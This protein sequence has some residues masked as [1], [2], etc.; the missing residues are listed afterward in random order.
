MFRPLR[1][2]RSIGLFL[3]S[4]SV[5]SVAW[6]QAPIAQFSGAPLTGN[7]PL[8]VFFTDFSTGSI[9]SRSWTFGDGGTSN[10]ED[11]SHE[12]TSPGTYTVSLSV[13]GPGGTDSE[14][15]TGY[16]VVTAPPPVANF[17]ATPLS[18]A[19][20]L[21]VAFTS[22][23]TGTITSG[24]WDFGDGTTSTVQNP[25]KLY[26]SPGTYTV[27]LTVS[28]PG[29][30]DTETKVGYITVANAPPVADFSGTPL[31]GMPPLTAFFTSLS[32]GAI[33]GYSW[34][35]GDG[36]TSTA[37][38]PSHAYASPG[39]YTVSLTV[40]GPGGTDTET[41][42]DY[43]TVG[44]LAP[45]AAFSGTPLSGVSPLTVGFTDLSTNTV[46]TRS[47]NFGDGGTSTA[48]NPS[49]VYSSPGSYTVSLTVT[50]PGGSDSEIK[51]DYVVVS[52]PPPVAQFFGSPLTGAAPLAVNFTDISSGVV[53]GRS[54]SFGDGISSTATNPSH[55]YTSPGSYT[56]SLTVVGPGGSDVETKTFYVVVLE[57]APVAQ[58]TG[59]PT[60]GVAPL[61][62]NFT[63][64]SS[65]NINT[66]SW[67]FGDGGSSTLEN[68]SH[69]Y[70]AAGTYTVSLTVSSA[71]GGDT[72]TKVG[73]ITVT[74]PP[75]VAE[76]SGT[77]LAG[78]P[79]LTV[80]FTNMST[81]AITSRLWD[82]GDLSTSTA[83][84][85]SHSYAATGA[86]TVTLTVTGPGGTD[87]ER[88]VGYVVVGQ[89]A[90]VAD[91]VGSPT[92][93]IKPLTVNFTNLTGGPN[94]SWSWTFGDGFGSTQ[95]N[96]SHTYANAGT[97]TVTLTSTG[98]GGSDSETKTNYI[99]VNEP[100]PVAEFSGTPTSGVK[101]LN[102]AFTDLSTGGPVTSR[103]WNFGDGGTS[104]AQNPSHTY[105]NA[106]VYTVTLTV[107]GPG[108]T[109]S[110]TKSGYITVNEPP[111]VANFSGTPTN[112]V[113][114][115]TVV[116]TNL[117]TG[118]PATAY[119]WTFGDG[120]TSNATS[121]TRVY[122]SPGV[123][124]V[125]LTATGPG[126]IDTETKT[127]YITVSEPPPVANFVGSPLNGTAPLTVNF[128]DLSVGDVDS[129]SWSFGDGG[130]A[131]VKNPAH[132]YTANGT[133]NVSLTVIGSGGV[134]TET[135]AGYVI[136]NDIV[137]N[138]VGA[139]LNGSTPLL[140]SF[141]D[142]STGVIA[143]RSWNFG[144]GGTSTLQNPTHSYSSAGSYTV[145][146]TV[147]G[148][149]GSDTETKVGYVVVESS[150]TEPANVPSSTVGNPISVQ[151]FGRPLTGPAPLT[152]HFHDV[153]IGKQWLSRDWDFGDGTGSQNGNPL[154]TYTSPGTYTVSLSRLRGTG[155]LVE[156]KVDYVVVTA[157]L[158]DGSFEDSEGGAQPS[159]A[160][161]QLS[162]TARVLD[163]GDERDG[164]MP[165]DGERWA[166]LAPERAAGAPD[167]LGRPEEGNPAAMSQS[168]HFDPERTVLVFHAAFLQGDSGQGVMDVE[169]SD[170]LTTHGLFHADGSSPFPW[171]SARHGQPMT[172][173]ERVR[174]DLAQL[175]P[176]AD[177]TTYL[178][179]TIRVGDP[180]S[181]ARAAR[182][183]V[184][185]FRLGPPAAATPHA[186]SDPE[187]FTTDLPVLGNA[188]TARVDSG[189]A[190][191]ANLSAVVG[192]DLVSTAPASPGAPLAAPGV[193][194]LEGLL[195]DPAAVRL[196]V[197]LKPASGGV[198]LHELPIPDDPSLLGRRIRVQGFLQAGDR[199]TGCD[200]LDLRIG[201]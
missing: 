149:S 99:T 186:G 98:P 201:F 7:A 111:P 67:D 113:A 62:V 41:K 38:N 151:F 194:T 125:S 152:V 37:Q 157:P 70:T 156:T 86:Y 102:V 109:N 110:E 180:G 161:T 174:T 100:P 176:A 105:A 44:Q 87:S 18:G 126:G 140:V 21:G 11:P 27:S 135:K 192:W 171:M 36:G 128:T 138:F 130:T 39:M 160:W 121:P 137:A 172:E 181:G 16:V 193:P 48:V 79:P 122:T 60:I 23:S 14:T 101:P 143:S 199:L 198:D 154:H 34:S 71:G 119:A 45:V 162:G 169:I 168:F 115:L 131:N 183:Y 57:P 155:L 167:H 49:H 56:V 29:G 175:F 184:D 123:Y 2:L 191:G 66:R 25:G 107:T 173:V 200:A 22:L 120:G 195:G 85:P 4:A 139:P 52:Y 185:H 13:S 28:G 51:A 32:S 12:Y 118:G 190:P 108:G 92:S 136:V 104:T 188:W 148:P 77:P 20:P 103:L 112:G 55:T 65:G 10:L 3:L 127:G 33:T 164:P 159:P 197:S 132:T 97:Y 133:Y 19:A 166:E 196:F 141:T 150:K 53:N 68:P 158:L 82:F 72:E 116:F 117:T 42:I 187:C 64:Y 114:P 124:T 59:V 179:L 47:W 144:D 145:S 1:A 30:S 96:P 95:Q 134:D 78:S 76:F 15:K 46:T 24:L 91:F 50:G 63:D 146:L 8:T 35:F 106:G 9:N 5:A 88:K 142:L 89:P 90:P 6:A 43:V 81:G 83:A 31:S 74:E 94:T 153:S 93:G 17:S 165:V 177:W 73:Y 129:W 80:S 170:G 61:T 189:A 147:T 69:T 84:N 163:L 178:T 40:T 54:W 58:F 75:P 182:G 26:T